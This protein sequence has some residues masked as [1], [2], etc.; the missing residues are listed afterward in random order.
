VLLTRGG[1]DLEIRRATI[2]FHSPSLD[3]LG[4]FGEFFRSSFLNNF[5]FKPFHIFTEF[6]QGISFSGA[7]PITLLPA[8]AEGGGTSP[9]GKLS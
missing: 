1:L 9:S 3:W 8:N 2:F 5:A 6:P 7:P 4:S